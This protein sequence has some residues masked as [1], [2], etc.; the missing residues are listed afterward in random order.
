MVANENRS[1]PM[2]EVLAT[3]HGVVE[4]GKVLRSYPNINMMLAYLLT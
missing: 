2:V 3:N 4:T 1:A